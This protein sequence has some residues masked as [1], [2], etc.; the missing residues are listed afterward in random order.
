MLKVFCLTIVQHAEGD[1]ANGSDK[2][3]GTSG[4]ILKRKAKPAATASGAR[5]GDLS[6]LSNGGVQKLCQVALPLARTMEIMHQ[7]VEGMSKEFR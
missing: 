5:P 3:T 7:D 4:I 1:A 6:V 2:D